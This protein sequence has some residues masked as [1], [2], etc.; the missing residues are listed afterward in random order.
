[1]LARLR[2]GHTA[3]D[4]AEALALLDAVG[5]AMRPSLLPFTP[6]STRADYAE[7][8]TFVAR[9]DLVECIDPVHFSIR[10]LVPPGSAILAE[11]PDGRHFGPLD[12]AGFQHPWRH[13]DPLM[14]ELQ[15]R[16]AAL[17]ERNARRGLPARET[18]AAIWRLTAAMT[19][20]LP[21]EPPAPVLARP[22]PPRLT[23]DWFC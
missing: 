23:E 13:E 20:L 9:H 11:D 15:G 21:P 5:I 19:D 4:V 10:L 14:D 6:W 7:L 22:W 2:K 8:L 3:A 17:V 16:V 1:V 18:F 12:A